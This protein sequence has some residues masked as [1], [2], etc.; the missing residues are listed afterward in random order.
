MSTAIGAPLTRVDGIAKVTGQAR[1]AAEFQL[2]DLAHGAIV[3]STIAKGRI[4][5][6]DTAAAE[7]APGVLA[8]LSHRNAPK[9][10]YEKPWPPP[11]VDPMVGH[12]LPMLQDDLVRHNG[13]HVALVVAETLEQ[14]T[15]AAD[16]VRIAYAEEPAAVTLE[17]ELAHAFPITEGNQGDGAPASFR[18]GE[19]ARALAAA[20]VRVDQTYLIARESHNPM[21]P[22]ATVAVWEGER[23]TL[24]DKTQWPGNVRRYVALTFGMDEEQIRVVSPFV[25]GAFGSAL[26]AWP[27]V[28]LAAM[29]AKKVDRPVKV[30]LTRRQMYASVGYRP[31]TIQRVALGAGR[32]GRLAATIHE[33]TAETS[34]YEEYTEQL[35]DATWSLYRCADLET[36]YR[37]VRLNVPSPTP[38]RGP[39]HVSGLFALECAMDELAVTLGIDPVELRLR[40][41]AERDPA[42]GRPWSSR[43]LA[44][45]CRLA[46]ERFGWQRRH[47]E[48]RSMRK[49]GQLVGYGMATAI[50]PARRAP[51]SASACILANG[52]AIVRSAASDMGPGTYTSMTQIAA[53][54]LGLPVSDVRFE[55]GDS[56]LP[57]APVHGGSMTLASVGPAVQ[58]ACRAAQQKVLEL[59]R[60]DRNS[61]L[62]GA[63]E[64]AV[65]F[66]DGRI[67][68][69]SDP[70]AGESYALI[71]RRHGKDGIE[72][73][74]E[75]KP[76]AEAKQ[77]S[78]QGFGALFAEVRVDP[79]FGIVRVARLV[80]AYGVG[81]IV[82]PKI[83]HSQCIG[84][85]VGGIGMALLE[86]ARVDPRCGRVTNANLAEYLVPV[87]ADVPEL[88]A[89][90]VDEHDPHV[91]P[92]G[93]KG[94]AEIAICGV[95]PAIANAVF[96][97]TGRRVEELPIRPEMLL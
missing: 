49:G 67:F 46:A 43:S 96:H 54:A 78:M 95:A 64:D 71:L 39:G 28:I 87:N 80:G 76:G 12:Q 44:A 42:D 70:S 40:N 55:L 20:E 83:A 61:P 63:D 25:G 24:Y 88:E 34:S 3:Q 52:S 65:A 2:P 62:H 84:G 51:A 18:R 57:Q 33:A 81:R 31:R 30:V 82:N 93:A 32:D 36:L 8:V 26:R 53:D 59:A 74:G 72:A 90:F 85:M 91:N 1:Y 13:Q 94:L 10:P 68:R 97:A 41:D 45:C 6:I 47:P 35:L 89:L 11:P 73:A 4:T 17:A 79:D 19:P 75:A 15:H 86:D 16:L 92:L 48:P 14:A 77:Y 60:G 66:A 27:H 23:L 69:K 58:A 50:Y 21:E 5:E 29:A 37:L 9:L 7:A 38:M 22:H 56:A